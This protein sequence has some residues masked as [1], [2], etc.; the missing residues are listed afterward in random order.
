MLRECLR[1]HLQ[2]KFAFHGK[3]ACVCVCSPE[4]LRNILNVT[5]CMIH[6]RY[7][8]PVELSGYEAGD[9][10]VVPAAAIDME[11]A[12]TDDDSDD[13]TFYDDVP[14]FVNFYF[15]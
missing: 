4:L 2:L 11:T 13:P 12:E 8:H 9:L 1:S 5:L 7:A 10:Y 6:R 3:F 14:P 15:Q